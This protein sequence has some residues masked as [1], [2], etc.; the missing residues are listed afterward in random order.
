MIMRR[1]SIDHIL[2]A[3]AEVTNNKRFVLVGSAALIARAK[4]VPLNMMYTPEID[5]YAPDADDVELASELIDGSI[6]QGSQFH[7]QFGYYGDGVSPATA[8]MPTDWSERATEYHGEECPGI[9]ALVPEENDLALAKLSAWRDK[10]QAWLIEGLKAGVLSLAQ[11]AAR[12]DRM[13]Q[14]NAEGNPPA[15]EIL[16]ER[17]TS[18]A[19]L[20]NIDIPKP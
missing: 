5:I 6:G 12:I 14:P 17:V 8:K 19:S 1:K 2:R 18:L 16:R 20:V 4:H 10:D 7:S 3:A 13:P 11:M 9:V 15:P